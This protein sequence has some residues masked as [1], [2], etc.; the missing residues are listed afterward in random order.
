MAHIN[1]TQ[2]IKRTAS[3]A[4]VQKIIP[5]YTQLSMSSSAEVTL[6]YRAAGMSEFYP[7]ED[8]TLLPNQGA[9]FNIPLSDGIRIT[10]VTS[11]V[12]F[13]VVIGQA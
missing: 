13:L 7:L 9:I 2:L 11:G 12:P 1:P 10:P 3:E 5:E 8:G 4:I 6:E